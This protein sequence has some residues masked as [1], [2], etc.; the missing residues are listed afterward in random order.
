MTTW[1]STSTPPSIKHEPTDGGVNHSD[2]VQIYDE[3][4]DSFGYGHYN[5]DGTWAHYG[6]DFG[7]MHIS[8]PTHWRKLDRPALTET[9]V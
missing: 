1:T 6:G 4:T 5:D 3:K 7:F 2:S 8:A 9:H